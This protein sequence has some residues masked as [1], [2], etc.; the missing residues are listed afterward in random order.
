MHVRKPVRSV[1]G[2]WVVTVSETVSPL[3][4]VIERIE[5]SGREEAWAAYRMI[6]KGL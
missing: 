2:T 5:C 1:N 4:P 6:M 3:S